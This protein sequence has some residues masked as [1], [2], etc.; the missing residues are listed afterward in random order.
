VT[1]PSVA[2][3]RIIVM[4]PSA[5]GKTTIAR[6]LAQALQARFLEGDELHPAVNVEKMRSGIALDDADRAPWLDAVG[7]ALCSD[8]PQAVVATCSALKRRYRDRLRAVADPL[9]FIHPIAS[10]DVLSQRLAMRTGHYMPA[11]LL[12]SQLADLEPLATD[13]SG[14][15]VDGAARVALQVERIRSCLGL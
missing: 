9:V 14:F 1:A 4:G 12:D 2:G 15:V 6:A 5:S 7:R 10:R 8:S 11:S 13:E 3:P